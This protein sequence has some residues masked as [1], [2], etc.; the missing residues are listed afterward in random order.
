V[1][2]GEGHAEECWVAFDNAKHELGIFMEGV[3]RFF[4]SHPKLTSGREPVIHS[5]RARLKSRESFVDKLERKRDKGIVVKPSN[6][7]ECVT[8]LAGVR[9]LHL[10]QAQFAEIHGAI[11]RRVAEQ[12]WVLGEPPTAYTWDPEAS[13]Y[14]RSLALDVKVRDTFYTSVHY[15][16]KPRPE[17]RYVCEIQ[18]RTLFEEIWG[19]ID[20]RLNYP[21]KTESIACKEQLRV[22]SKLVSAGSR[23]VDAI[24]RSHGE[25]LEASRVPGAGALRQSTPPSQPALH[26]HE[27]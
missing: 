27:P 2:D 18:V 7:F 3:A 26:T 6:L 20:H 14:F 16:V 1:L 5:V 10:H 23:L 13:E 4:S 21:R 17:S 19:E 22:L 24:I 25:H 9:V 15:L 11:E 12:D 8:D